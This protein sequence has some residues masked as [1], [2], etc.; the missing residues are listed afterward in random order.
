[1]LK[2]EQIKLKNKNNI[3]KNFAMWFLKTVGRVRC[4]N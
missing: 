3:V 2:K 1:M 4:V